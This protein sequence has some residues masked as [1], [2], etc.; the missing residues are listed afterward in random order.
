MS[1]PFSDRMGNQLSWSAAGGKIA[2]R[3][4]S[5]R[6]DLLLLWLGVV[7]VIPSHTLR[8]LFYAVAGV[9][10]G[11]RST[12][13]TGAKFY[14]PAGITIGEG[15]IV[16][17]H[18]VLD[19]RAPLRIG[20]HVDIASQVMIYNSEHDINSDDFGPISGPVTI[21]DYVFIGPRA[22]ILPGV[23]LGEGAIVAAG[24]VVTKNVDPHTIVGGV[25]AK[26]IGER[27]HANGY[28]Y[29]L[30]RPRLFQ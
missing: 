25:P 2:R 1:S 7:A 12:I 24:A 15:T 5:Y 28:H 4:G 26:P 18:A 21:G 30:G 10:I 13:H 3:F 23:T 16:G 29:R 17:D 8:R 27:L 20:D 14:H 6:E 22:I 11:S 9:K 19:G